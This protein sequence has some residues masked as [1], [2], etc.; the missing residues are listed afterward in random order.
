MKTSIFVVLCGAVIAT[1]LSARAEDTP[2]QAA[3]RAAMEQ[4][5]YELDHP[6]AQPATD[7]NSAPV[8]ARPAKPVTKT[9]KVAPA[10][11]ASTPAVA[12][13]TVPP[14]TIPAATPVAAAPA[15]AAKAASASTAPA[16]DTFAPVPESDATTASAQAAALAV[17][18]QK[19]NEMNQ[20]QP[21]PV[22]ETPLARAPG[23]ISPGTAPS[24]AAPL[25]AA[26]AVVAPAPKVSLA[27]AAAVATTEPVATPTEALPASTSVV[28]K[29]ALA[30]NAPTLPTSSPGQARPANELA[31][32]GVIYKNVEVERVKDDGIVIS[33]E[34]VNGGWAMTNINF[35]DLPIELRQQYGK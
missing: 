16:D 34:P 6:Q 32:A 21:Q 10:Q 18:N 12:P 30:P 5:L 26:P 15:K 4:K 13:K 24:E 29:P 25:S 9:N 27:P 7:T 35:Q 28:I 20:P 8:T 11:V 2:D 17:V 22:T 33:Y 14:K 23:A 3:A 19:L 31:I 1:C